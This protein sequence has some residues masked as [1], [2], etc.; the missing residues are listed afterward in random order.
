M[1]KTTRQATLGGGC[2]WCLEAVFEQLHGVD[3]VVSGYAGGHVENPTYKQVCSGTTGHAEVVQLTFDEAEI[4]YRE[5]LEIFLTMHDPTT[6]DRQGGDVGP[7][8]RSIVLFHDEE[9]RTTA[10][11]VIREFQAEKVWDDPI[12]TEIVPLETFYPA[13]DYHQDYYRNNPLQPY[14]QVAIAPK[15]SKLRQQYADRL[16]EKAG[17]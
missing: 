16:K 8:Y 3:E 2:F 9:Q 11:H 1:A 5:L 13:E 12:V 10:E 4:S 15:V 14:C 6:K 17:A 7:Q